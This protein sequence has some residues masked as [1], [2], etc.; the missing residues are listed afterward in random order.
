M[1]STP[2]RQA[3]AEFS[4]LIDRA[5]AGEPQRVTRNGTAAVVIV[6]EAAWTRRSA[7]E[8]GTLGEL[9][10]E[11]AHAHGFCE[12]D[13]DRPWREGGRRLGTDFLG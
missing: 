7:T 11:H 9:L 6:S 12:E 1:R 8:A 2:L 3:R 13:F 10:A 4:K 5:L